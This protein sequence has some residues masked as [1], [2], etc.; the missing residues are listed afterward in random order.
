MKTKYI[1]TKN[2]KGIDRE[3]RIVTGIAS[4]EDV[5][6]H[7]EIIKADGWILDEFKLNPIILYAH[8]SF[9]GKPIA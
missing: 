7:G 3:N 1:F 5:D 4:T 9:S 6:R 2:L 8:N